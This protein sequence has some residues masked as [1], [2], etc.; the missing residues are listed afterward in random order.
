MNKVVAN[1]DEAIRD[2]K[3]NITVMV[4]GFGLCG[5]PE[6]SIA[7]MVKKG[8]K[9]LTCISNNAGVDDFGLGLLLHGR[10]IKKMISSYVGENAEFE[11]QLLSGE[12]EVD[13]IPQGTLA[14]RCLAAGYGMPAIFTAAGVGTE[15]AIGKETR[16]FNGKD[17]LMEYAF[18]AD[19]A[20]VKA[21]KGD[22][23]GNLIFHETARNFN[24]LMAMAG[25]ITIAE[26][27]E[28]VPAGE[29]DPNNIHTP[30]IYV[31]RIFKGENYEKRI[32]QR[33][34]QNEINFRRMQINTHTSWSKYAI[35]TIIFFWLAFFIHEKEWLKQNVVW[36]VMSYYGYLPAKFIYH[37]IT[38]KFTL[39]DVDKFRSLFLADL[40]PNGEM[41]IKTTMGLSFLYAPF[42]LIANIFAK[43]F[44]FPVDG[45]SM[46]YQVGLMASAFFYLIV[47][48]IF[49][50]KLLRIYFDEVTTALTII[51]I[52]FGSNLLWYTTG[53]A[54]MSH[55]YLFSITAIYFYLML[56][57]YERETILRT[58]I[59]GLL[60]GLMVLIRPTMV[61]LL[62]PFIFYLWGKSGSISNFFK[63]VWE[64]KW[65]FILMI[66]VCF[67]V[68]V[69]QL[70]YWKELTGNY[71]YFSYKKER[72]YFNNPY[73]L[74]GLFSYRKGWLLYSPIMILSVFGLFVMRNK[75]KDFK[76]GIITTFF[77][78]IFVFFSWWTWWFGGSFGSRP[79]IDL[80]AMLA[81]PFAASIDFFRMNK[82]RLYIFVPFGAFFLFLGAFQN[83]QYS[84]G[85]I[86]YDSNTK[87]SYWKNFLRTTMDETWWDN[88]SPPDYDAAA[89]G[90]ESVVRIGSTRE[91]FDWKKYQNPIHPLFSTVI[92]NIDNPY[93]SSLKIPLKK[94]VEDK[95]DIIYFNAFIKCD[96]PIKRE[97]VFFIFSFEN[98]SGIVS[99]VNRD[100]A[101][102]GKIEKGNWSQI[103]VEMK[104]DSTNF[105]TATF[106][107]LF[108][109]KPSKLKIMFKDYSITYSILK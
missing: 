28:L 100:L 43:S 44:G 53:E 85:M 30:G 38:L 31:H 66:M 69:P 10:Q 4:G 2:M 13:L 58:I 82:K 80:Y 36:D 18:D 8:L 103:E 102:T 32:E 22:T 94:L 35:W 16:N 49:I 97:D 50:R 90:I 27:E 106:L 3:D 64:R 56:K 109:H 88:I 7:A 71:F 74:D 17:Y 59:L 104:V 92:L 95:I 70:I 65:K 73:I 54:L 57:W 68:A 98:D 86:H 11:R 9:G 79:M 75:V 52:Y 101:I 60:I 55:G 105:K 5:I 1:A 29:L 61:L 45:F 89:L 77:I 25:K 91:G 26:V 24:P 63:Y 42:F 20:V 46:P 84:Q 21:W 81:L 96:E 15:V 48:M 12:L 78:S 107:N 62:L 76:I 41:V 34:V 93:S 47:G 67:L 72:F 19:F 37:D 23:H 99:I 87:I 40:A 108:V 33:T 83:W 39:A 51:G 6:N 14:T